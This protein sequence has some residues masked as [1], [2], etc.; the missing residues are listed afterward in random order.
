MFCSLAR[1][2]C[3]CLSTPGCTLIVVMTWEIH[4]DNRKGVI[5][6][7]WEDDWMPVDED[8][9]RADIICSSNSTVARSN[10]GR[11]FIPYFAAAA[12]DLRKRLLKL[13]GVPKVIT[14][15]SISL[16]DENVFN[17]I[18]NKLLF[19][20]SI[21]SPKMF[22]WYNQ[23]VVSK[24]ERV[25]HVTKCLSKFIYLFMPVDNPIN[26]I[27]AVIHLEKH[28]PQTYGKLRYRGVGGYFVTTEDKVRITPMYFMVLEK[29]ADD[30]SSANIGKRQHHGLLAS[31]T[32]EEKYAQN[33]RPNHTRNFGE[34]EMRL[35]MFYA[36]SIK[37]A[38]EIHDRSNNPLTMH[39]IA[40]E[41]LTNEKPTNIRRL[42][43]RDVIEYGGV[44]IQFLQHFMRTSGASIEHMN[45]RDA[46]EIGY[47]ESFNEC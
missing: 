24:E 37:A 35:T 19:F 9:N 34:A 4:P 15:E 27:D 7:I 12:R 38:A 11:S 43:P 25:K 1:A 42:V 17:D 22:Y 16:M 21:L 3:G 23:V 45:E 31:Q 10:W 36:R 41:F 33:Y 26:D 39:Y 46:M 44:P 30:G 20:Y 8:G 13:E 14:E 29:I 32:K 40:K 18:Y 28:F 47:K 6:Q 2:K 5:V